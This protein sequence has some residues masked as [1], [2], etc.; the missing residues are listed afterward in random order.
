MVVE[1]NLMTRTIQRTLSV[2][3]LLLS[4]VGC[5]VAISDSRPLTFVAPLEGTWTQ[6]TNSAVELRIT[7]PGG[8]DLFAGD[9]DFTAEIVDTNTN[10]TTSYAGSATELTFELRD[11]DTDAI[12]LTGE[13][14]LESAAALVLSDGDTYDKSFRPD[15]T[16][17]VWQDVNHPTRFYHFESQDDVAET[18]GGCATDTEPNSDDIEGV[19]I[20]EF[21]GEDVPVFRVTDGG[22]LS[23]RSA[24]FFYGASAMRVKRVDGFLH[25]QRVDLVGACP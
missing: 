10:D 9:F 2:A 15:L 23:I 1:R 4:A 21:A 20:A 17:G 7:I 3:I 11:P 24:G 25:L 5:G 13:M 6:R 22:V 16:S 8:Q 14:L 12:V 18:A 19:L